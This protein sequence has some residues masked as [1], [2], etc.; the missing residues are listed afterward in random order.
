MVNVG[1]SLIDEMGI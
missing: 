1:Y